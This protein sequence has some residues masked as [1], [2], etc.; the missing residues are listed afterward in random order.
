M[1]LT[2]IVQFQV[3]SFGLVGF[4]VGQGGR[5]LGCLGAGSGGLLSVWVVGSWRFG[6]V[7]LAGWLGVG[8]S[9]G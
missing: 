4:R 5:V 8:P 2:L 1:L 9:V 7:C 6:V 3:S